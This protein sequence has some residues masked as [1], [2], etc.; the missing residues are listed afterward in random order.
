MMEETSAVAAAAMPSADSASLGA[1]SAD[2]LH[3]GWEAARNLLPPI[4]GRSTGCVVT[5]EREAATGGGILNATVLGDSGFMVLSPPGHR[6][7]HDGWSV[8]YT[9]D[10]ER[11][12]EQQHYFNCPFQLGSLGGGEMN[13]PA[14]AFHARVPLEHGDVVIVATDGLFDTLFDEDIANMFDEY[15]RSLYRA[16]CP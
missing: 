10:E 6:P 14:D 9:C 7:N 16:C 15:A 12:E 3:G 8:R 1:T 11:I 13:T 5:V 4:E 2:I